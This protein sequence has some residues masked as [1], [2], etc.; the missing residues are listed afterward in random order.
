M[1]VPSLGR[2]RVE[3]VLVIRSDLRPQGPIY[4]SLQVAKLVGCSRSIARN[5]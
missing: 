3:E 5:L 1:E 4:T 2:W